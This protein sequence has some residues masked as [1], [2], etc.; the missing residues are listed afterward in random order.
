[1]TP[2]SSQPLAQPV[3]LYL[4]PC[5]LG[6]R[7]SGTG[8]GGWVRAVL[9][10]WTDHRHTLWVSPVLAVSASLAEATKALQGHPPSCM[11]CMC[12]SLGALW[13]CFP[14]PFSLSLPGSLLVQP[15][16]GEGGWL[17]CLLISPVQGGKRWPLFVLTVFKRGTCDSVVYSMSSPLG[18]RKSCHASH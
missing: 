11:G 14:P 2:S 9:S 13:E 15:G 4:M 5:P 8:T 6:S 16:W 1:M 7:S 17:D 12:D 10:L 18:T 3:S